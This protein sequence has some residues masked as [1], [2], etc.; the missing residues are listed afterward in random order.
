MIKIEQRKVFF[1]G[2]LVQCPGC[3][4]YYP[5]HEHHDV[6]TDLCV[7]CGEVI[8]VEVVTISVEV[9]PG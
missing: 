4:Y 2:F 8:D 7:A 5:E 9:Q 3:E 6:H 1:M